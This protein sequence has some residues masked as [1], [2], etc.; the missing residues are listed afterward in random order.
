[1]RMT[2]PPPLKG[3][4]IKLKKC[5]RLSNGLGI[6]LLMI[7]FVALANVPNCKEWQIFARENC[8][9]IPP[10]TTGPKLYVEIGAIHDR[11]CCVASSRIF[12]LEG[13]SE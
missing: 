3:T 2:S 1:M 5:S 12:R 8:T 7:L 4:T 9:D 11:Y 6:A 10:G 13:Q